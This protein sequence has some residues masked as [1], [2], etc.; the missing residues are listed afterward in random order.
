MLDVGLC[1]VRDNG[2]IP[3]RGGLCLKTT[4]AA[5]E[6]VEEMPQTLCWGW[7]LLGVWEFKE[8]RT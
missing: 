4:G 6:L 3:G 8:Q 5:G 7:A 1:F 2:E